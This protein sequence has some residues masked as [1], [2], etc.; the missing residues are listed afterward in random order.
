LAHVL[1]RARAFYRFFFSGF[2]PAEVSIACNK[3]VP[4]TIRIEEEGRL[5]AFAA[6]R[7]LAGGSFDLA[8]ALIYSREHRFTIEALKIFTLVGTEGN[9]PKQTRSVP[10]VIA[11]A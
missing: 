3:P 1:W 10:V 8:E 9:A 11:I 6:F 2:P 5:V 4:E 7:T